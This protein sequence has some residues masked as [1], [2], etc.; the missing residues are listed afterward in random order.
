MTIALQAQQVNTTIRG[1]IV[2]ASI[3][4]PVEGAV[5]TL[6]HSKKTFVSK[7]DGR[8]TITLSPVTDSLFISH[9]SYLFQRIAVNT[10]T[11]ALLITLTEACNP[12]E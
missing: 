5:I 7:S 11:T 10:A 12:N 3:R 4:E 9:I 2:V 1:K 8:F 6:A